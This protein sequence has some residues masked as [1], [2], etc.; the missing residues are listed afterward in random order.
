MMGRGLECLPQAQA[1]NVIAISG[2]EKA[3]LKS[4]TLTSTPLASPL[5]PMLFQVLASQYF[6]ALIP[7]TVIPWKY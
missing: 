3:I 2:L 1:G 6:L 7:D 5:A 4:A